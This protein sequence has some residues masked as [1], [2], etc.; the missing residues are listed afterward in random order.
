MELIFVKQGFPGF[1]NETQDYIG[2]LDK[3]LLNK[4]INFT[5]LKHSYNSN[6]SL[7]WKILNTEFYLKEIGY[8][9]L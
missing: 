1:P 5:K 4:F 8:K 3:F 7:Q 2:T 9:Y 6:K